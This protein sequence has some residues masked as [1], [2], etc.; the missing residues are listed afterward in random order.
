M[1]PRGGYK[2]LRIFGDNFLAPIAIKT[3]ISAPFAIFFFIELDIQAF[4]TI[5]DIVQRY[6]LKILFP[7]I[8]NQ[9]FGILTLHTAT[10]IARTFLTIYVSMLD[11]KIV[12]TIVRRDLK[13]FLLRLSQWLLSSSGFVRWEYKCA[14]DCVNIVISSVRH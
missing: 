14:R 2:V 7:G 11:G 5:L 8:W 4:C 6:L 3:Q 13:S 12:R 10:L 1:L 9:S